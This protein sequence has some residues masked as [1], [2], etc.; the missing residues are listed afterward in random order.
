VQRVPRDPLGPTAQLGARPDEQ[1]RH[2]GELLGLHACLQPG[3]QRPLDRVVRLAPQG[4][5]HADLRLD[6]VV[7]VPLPNPDG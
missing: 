1:R 4:L 2:V 5:V 6:A 7:A 3:G